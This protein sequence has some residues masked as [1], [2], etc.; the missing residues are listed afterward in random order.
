MRAVPRSLALIGAWGGLL[1]VLSWVVGSAGSQ[2]A[3][4]R[5]PAPE[6]AL[7]R[8][9]LNEIAWSGTQFSSSDEWIELYNPTDAPIDLAG[10]RLA[11]ADGTPDMALWGIIPARGYFLLERTDD[12]SVLD[13]PADLIF[14]L[15]LSN[16]G[17]HLLLWNGGVLVDSVDA[18]GGWPAG[19]AAPDYRSMER[20][21]ISADS[22]LANWASNNG[23]VRS[24]LDGGGAPLNGTPKALNSASYANLRVRKQGPP[25]ALPGETITY[26]LW[27]SNT[28]SAPALGAWMTDRLPA[29]LLLVGQSSHY[30]F[31]QAAPDTW[32]WDLGAVSTETAAAPLAITLTARIAQGPW[33]DITNTVTVSCQ[34]TESRLDD[35]V[36][37]VTTLSGEAAQPQVLIESLYARTYFG[38]Y[39]EAFRLM[40]ASTL[41]A[42]LAGWTLTDGPEEGRV[43]FPSGAELA[44]GQRIWCSRRAVEF[45]KAFGFLPDYEWKGTHPSVPDLGYGGALRFHDD[46]DDV[47]LLDAEGRQV[48]T[49]VYGL[50]A[51]PQGGGWVGSSLQPYAPTTTFSKGGQILY[52]KRDQATG[53]PVTDTDTAADWA[54]DPTDAVDGSK[55]Q[56]PGWDLDPFFW[57]AQVTETATLTVAVGPD[58]LLDTLRS[59]IEAAQESIWIEAYTFESAVLAT[60]LI[61]RLKAGVSVTLLLEAGPAGG[62][63]DAQRWICGRLRDEGAHVYF[64][65]SRDPISPRYRS[66]HAKVFLIDNRLALIGSENLNPSGMP[67]DPKE[68]GT[69]GRRGVYLITDAPGVVERVRAILTADIDPAHH[70][71]LLTCAELANAC[72]GLAPGPETNWISYTVAFAQPLTV[73][74]TLAFEVVHSPENSLRAREGLL[75]MVGRAG[76]GDTVLVEQF[77]ERVHWGAADATPAT[78]PNLRLEAYLAA[79]RRGARVRILLDGFFEAW[80]NAE[81]AS[82]LQGVARREGLDLEVRLANPTF[83]GLHNKMVLAEIDGRGFVH[84]GSINGSEVS[85]K[86]NREVALQVQSDAAYAYLKAVFEH[87]WS[88]TRL[89]TYLPVVVR[90]HEGPQPA[91]HLL[92]AELYYRDVPERQWV[93]LYNPTSGPIHLGGSKIGDAAN[94]GDYEGMYA[95]PEGVV[96]GPG[97]LLVVAVNAAQ[98][99]AAF[100]RRLPDF[101]LVDSDAS[102]PNLAKVTEWS[103]G[104][105]WLARDGDE[106]LL[107]DSNNVVIDAVAY[108]D[109]P[110]P[111]V[112]PHPGVDYRHSLERYP[113]WLDTDDCSLDFRAQPYPHPGALP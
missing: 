74:G 18:S 65:A 24:G 60:A 86:A 22:H 84:V 109:S 3:P 113:V 69:A 70:L 102:V 33:I 25:T 5:L 112:V 30:P 94:Q 78:A 9:I 108:G 31:Y 19:S 66:Q 57:T 67:D 98:F 7:P 85:S 13:V 37:R 51:A 111:L 35:N 39:D 2:A 61:E 73:R 83:L 34:T 28:G 76:E 62:M 89:D 10:W 58:H 26:T 90:A 55:V 68:D 101:E 29:N 47:V 59:R 100:P 72:T 52:R 50:G 106:V 88:T 40:N 99:Q 81:T 104:I 107:M 49:L 4:N 80:Q 20:I 96:L 103:S 105:W 75:G 38:L 110:L 6:E 48:D 16:E 11:A 91:H 56:Y 17:E 63:T 23:L 54:Q 93:E 27:V 45:E 95:F 97:Q 21:T 42:S 8:V 43:I 44:P 12:Q 77:Y 64:L 79:A 82:Y 41:T 14:S 92:I 15:G 53:W 32:T 71:D 36:D 46:G 87:D 1:L